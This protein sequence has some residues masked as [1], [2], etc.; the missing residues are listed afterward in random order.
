MIGLSTIKGLR[1]DLAGKKTYALVAF[2]IIAILGQF[3]FSVDFG[4]D[5]IPPAQDIGDVIEQAYTFLIAGT[6]RAAIK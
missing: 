1:E 5:A 4:I 6:F 3:L 2:A